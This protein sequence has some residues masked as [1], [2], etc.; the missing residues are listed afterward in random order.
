MANSYFIVDDHEMLRSGII[1]WLKDNTDYTCLGDAGT[2]E[3][4]M[5]S[6]VQLKKNAT[7]PDILISD[8][9]FNGENS[10]FNLIAQ[11]REKYPE[12]KIV[13]YSMFYSPNVMKEAVLRGASGYI[14]K[15][16]KTEELVNCMNTVLT[17]NNYLE[18]NLVQ[19]YINYTNIIDSL[20][21]REAVVVSLLLE[22][23][24]NDEIAD[25]LEIKK[26]SVENY[27]SS[28]Y[29]KIG[30]IDRSSLI[31]KLS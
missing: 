8:I 15:N 18:K 4:A 21:K 31:A 6:L 22:H 12:I 11:V 20:T 25:A 27:I 1:G 28:I 23:K 19:N 3:A 16:A 30:V 13:V 2:L 7:L 17:G 10:G 26:R 29:E 5:D 14:S 9:N 24:S